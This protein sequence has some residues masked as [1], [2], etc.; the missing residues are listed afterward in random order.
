MG[1]SIALFTDIKTLKSE[2][3]V[4]VKPVINGNLFI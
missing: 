4:K 1:V 3:K 2:Y